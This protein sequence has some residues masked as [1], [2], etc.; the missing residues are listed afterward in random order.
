MSKFSLI[1]VLGF[2]VATCCGLA[3]TMAATDAMFPPAPGAKPAIDFD[4]K[5]F[6]I[7]GERTHLKSGLDSLSARAQGSRHDRLL[8]MARGGYN[9]VQTY[10]FLELTTSPRKTTSSSAGKKTSRAI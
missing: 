5:G 8:R 3:R 6:V 10:V 2:C 7:N 4:G 1:V 9:T